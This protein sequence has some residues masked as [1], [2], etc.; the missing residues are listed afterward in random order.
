MSEI[1]KFKQ[2]AEILQQ[3]DVTDI[4][5]SLAVGIADAQEKLDNN[6]IKQALA[7]ADPANGVGGKSLLKM[8]FAPSFYH[9]QYADVSAEIA[10]KMRLQTEFELDASLTFNYT[11]QG[12]YSAEKLDYLRE[13]KSSLDRKEF[14]SSR[15]FVTHADNY[16]DLT[17]ESEKVQMDQSQGCLRRIENFADQ[18]RTNQRI[19]RVLMDIKDEKYAAQ[20]ISTNNTSVLVRNV[21]GYIVITLPETDPGNNE[22]ILKV[23][24]YTLQTSTE[25]EFDNDNTEEFEIGS[26][27]Q[28]TFGDVYGASVSAMGTGTVV[29][30]DA[31]DN[32]FVDS[33]DPGKPLEVYFDY[34]KWDARL[35]LDSNLND[36]ANNITK[37]NKADMLP[38][39]KKLAKALI[40]DPDGEIRII[41]H[42]DGSGSS[43]YNNKLSLKR[44]NSLKDWFVD[45]GVDPDQVKTKGEGE[46]LAG[47]DQTKNLTYR[48]TVIE[49][50]STADYFYYSGG[51]FIAANASPAAAD[52][53]VNKFVYTYTTG[54]SNP[55]SGGFGIGFKSNGVIILDESSNTFNTLSEISSHQSIQ[56]SFSSEILGD[57]LYLLHNESEIKYTTYTNQQ[58]KQTYAIGSRESEDFNDNETRYL[59]DEDVN[60][61][62]RIKKDQESRKNPSTIAVGASVDVRVARQFEMDVS[63]N[64]KVSA[65]MVSLPAPPEFLDEIKTYY[66]Q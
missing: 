33:N 42:T 58:E 31:S 62:T 12:G 9:F 48:K 15:S 53:D 10:L 26:G 4:I 20:D 46:T 38:I 29:G 32:I 24:D 28:D 8:G 44:S 6:S 34:D 52:P 36:S 49:F 7:L 56:D 40:N 39:L 47:T 22:G 13:D 64:A 43:G 16:E 27:N 3:V 23:A 59:I 11:Q 50:I 5:T 51:N 45:Q 30:F 61:Q 21:G 66:N 1:E 19:D 25:I 18:I 55:L 54:G 63:G 60:S 57:S 14:K 41:G 35:A 37:N 2:G 17:I 65:R